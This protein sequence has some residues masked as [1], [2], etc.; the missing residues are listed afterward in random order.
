MF[1]CGQE[2][3]LVWYSNVW[4]MFINSIVLYG[5]LVLNDLTL[6]RIEQAKVKE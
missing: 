6:L 2:D 5:H 4:V 3:S 1:A